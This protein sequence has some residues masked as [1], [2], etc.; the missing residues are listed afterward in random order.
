M[1][2]RRG[3]NTCEG[4]LPTTLGDITPEEAEKMTLEQV[5]DAIRAEMTSGR[6]FGEK[7]AGVEFGESGAKVKTAPVRTKRHLT[8]RQRKVE[9]YIDLAGGADDPAN[10]ETDLL[11]LWVDCGGRLFDKMPFKFATHHSARSKTGVK[12]TRESVA[13]EFGESGTFW[14]SLDNAERRIFFGTEKLE[15]GSIG[16]G[17]REALESAGI[18]R[19]TAE[20]GT[21]DFDAAIAEFRRQWRNYERGERGLRERREAQLEE[22]REE[23]ERQEDE[24]LEAIFG[25]EDKSLTPEQIAA[26]DAEIEASRAAGY[27]SRGNRD[28]RLK[29]SR[30]EIE[31]R[32]E[33]AKAK[34]QVMDEALD[35]LSEIQK[36]F[37]A[38]KEKTGIGI[39]EYYKRVNTALGANHV[40]EL[41]KPYGRL[42]QFI[43]DGDLQLKLRTLMLKMKEQY[44][45]GHPF[46]F[47]ETKNLVENVSNPPLI[48]RRDEATA[49][50]KVFFEA[51]GGRIFCASIN[52][53]GN[54][55]DIET[56]YPK[57]FE[58]LV[59]TI[60][61]SKGKSKDILDVDTSKAVEM[62]TRRSNTALG[63]Q[64]NDLEAAISV[65]NNFAKV[66][67]RP[68][69]Q[70]MGERSFNGVTP[71]EDAA[72]A[73]AVKRGD[74][75][76]VRHN[77]N[78]DI[79][80]ARGGNPPEAGFVKLT[81][82]ADDAGQGER[83]DAGIA[84]S[85]ELSRTAPVPL[86]TKGTRYV[87]LPLSELHA[88]A[89]HL[90][91][92]AMPGEME[93]GKT[94]G[95]A[96][97]ASLKHRKLKIAADV[98]GV[99][100]KTDLDGE[101]NFL[102]GKGLF[103]HEDPQWLAHHSNADA[104][105]E[106]KQ[107]EE[108][109]SRRL[110]TLAAKRISGAAAGGET[111]ARR[112]YADQLAKIV[113][114]MPHGQPGVLG[115]LQTVAGALQKRVNGGEAEA[116]AFLDWAEGKK[117]GSAR[118]ATDRNILWGH[119]PCG[120]PVV[121]TNVTKM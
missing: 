80:F 77:Q 100:D 41:G 57:D 74:M 109:L 12:R 72:Y 10:P 105:A 111:A 7:F 119:S 34:G 46:T 52:P 96:G 117:P 29:F 25:K 16:E 33:D 50:A 3:G 28:G 110:D 114:A 120:A 27:F 83:T 103:R 84:A 68:R 95:A 40:F 79:R 18:T 69:S 115:N 9:E 6:K 11:A 91:G 87:A 5:A 97:K 82:V 61:R 67:S 107:S 35:K 88:L 73:E 48:M 38:E 19:F 42:A 39:G 37:A 36:D 8:P 43:P 54:I 53:E 116:D 70:T 20:D 99:V 4:T 14:D 104:A 24:E 86:N 31:K 106:R 93:S 1:S 22:E 55:N 45:S 2:P 85:V 56:L 32:A 90:T 21:V 78:N 102:K 101:K 71:A 17:F 15:P 76:T 51:P 44:K 13:D 113:M 118:T 121:K 26:V 47:A 108:A 60:A 63:E 89:R 112:V 66:N 59:K 92:N 75:E 30:G 64:P 62:L 23:F 65:L 81:R 58:K 94:L 98:L 49:G